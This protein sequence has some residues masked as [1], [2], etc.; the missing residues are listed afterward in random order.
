MS[1]VS[2][3]SAAMSVAKS[4]AVGVPISAETLLIVA[5][6]LSTMRLPILPDVVRAEV[7]AS[8]MACTPALDSEKPVLSLTVTLGVAELAAVVI[9]VFI[10]A[11]K[12]P[13]VGAATLMPQQAP[14]DITLIIPTPVRCHTIGFLTLQARQSAPEKT[15]SLMHHT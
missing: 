12:S 8:Q 1:S 9:L 6:R 5:L 10:V 11:V 2:A 13:L 4:A 15:L 14:E 3:C 7:K